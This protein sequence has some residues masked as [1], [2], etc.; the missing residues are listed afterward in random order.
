MMPFR[1]QPLPSSTEIPTAEESTIESLICFNP[2]DDMHLLLA[3]MAMAIATIFT[4]FFCLNCRRAH[5]LYDLN[6]T[7]K[8]ERDTASQRFDRLKRDVIALRRDIHQLQF[9]ETESTISRILSRTDSS[10]T[11][12]SSPRKS[13]E[14]APA[15]LEMIVV[16][17]N[18]RLSSQVREAAPAELEIVVETATPKR[19]PVTG[20][21]NT[22]INMDALD[23]HP[24]D[25]NNEVEMVRLTYLKRLRDLHQFE[26]ECRRLT[27]TMSAFECEFEENDLNQFQQECKRLSRVLCVFGCAFDDAA[28]ARASRARSSDEYRNHLTKAIRDMRFADNN[29]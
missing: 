23:G 28:V 11:W 10:S 8:K 25:D 29:Q 24:D 19:V 13:L 18:R 15:E 4:T 17:D 3:G 6:E 2:D 26:R 1:S 16:H 27:R 7:Y 9:Q 22:I 14:S 20:W 5:S 12:S 21:P